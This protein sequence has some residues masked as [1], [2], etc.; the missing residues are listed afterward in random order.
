MAGKTALVLAGGG[1][2]GAVYEIGAL[3][4]I[5]DLLVDRSVN[6]FDIFVGTSA[7]A[8]VAAMLANGMSP[9][10]MLQGLNGSHPEIRPIDRR[11]I[12]SLNYRDLLQTGLK[13]P[14]KLVSAWSSFWRQRPEMTVFDFVW[15]LSEALPAGV[16]DSLALERYVRHVLSYND[17]S[18]DFTRLT[19]ALYIIATN[20]DN[21]ER[22]VFS[23]DDQSEVPI[24]LAVAA[25]SALPIFY[26]PVRIGSN[27]Y[28]DGGL[29]GNAS[30]DLAIEHGA[31]L[32]VC[33]NPV[34]PYDNSDRSSIPFLEAAGGYLSD[35]GVQ[36]V[37]SQTLAILL[38][39]GLHYHI[40]Q[41]RRR[42]P[43]VDIILVEPQMDD[44]TMHFDNIMRYGARLTTARHGF[45]SVTLDLA[46]DFA[47]YKAVL[48]R[49]GIPIT[50]RL[51]IE[52]M[53][54]L[55]QSG[56]DPAVL[57]RI[58]Y[59]RP[60]GVERGTPTGELTGCLARLDTLLD[61]LALNMGERLTGNGHRPD[62]DEKSSV[63]NVELGLNS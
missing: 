56:N 7:G 18:N 2:T 23:K 35:K 29:R 40:K 27:E 32:V 61:S 62:Y 20:L 13:L 26:N 47:Y 50:R 55:I 41:L 37:T 3:R 54:E 53:Q 33:I 12:L 59:D 60:A 63:L 31:T 28:V 38:H 17:F 43:D 11:D 46:Q 8:L 44:E 25:S 15:S 51:L 10:M 9:S 34:V 1:V 57:R 36:A 4:A 24:S 19:R 6:D 5:D 42:H 14:R 22:V 16:Y 52:D 21:G 49:H 39:S 45:E 48:A 30:L 58:L